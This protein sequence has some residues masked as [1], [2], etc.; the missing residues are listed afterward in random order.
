MNPESKNDNIFSHS[1]DRTSYSSSH[2]VSNGTSDMSLIT[3]NDEQNNFGVEDQLLRG[4]T[5]W[6]LIKEGEVCLEI[7]Q[8]LKINSIIRNPWLLVIC[9]I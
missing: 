1:A 7:T 5:N 3:S 8:S 6:E 2:D 4:C 9:L